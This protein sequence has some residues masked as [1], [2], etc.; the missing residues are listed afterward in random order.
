[1][2]VTLIGGGGGGGGYVDL[3]SLLSDFFDVE[4]GEVD[5][6]DDDNDGIS[7]Q[8]EDIVVTAEKINL[9]GGYYA[10]QHR[11]HFIIMKDGWITNTYQGTFTQGTPQDHDFVI[12]DSALEFWVKIKGVEA[13]AEVKPASERYFKSTKK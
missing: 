2:W 7:N 10:Y 13:G 9:P 8:D 6:G 4:D 3:A 1:M 12:K 5:E 11:G